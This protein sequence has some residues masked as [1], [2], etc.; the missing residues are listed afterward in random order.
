MSPIRPL[1]ENRGRDPRPVGTALE[2]L[3]RRLGAPAA[4][5][6]SA[7]F[8]QWDDIVGEV[9]AAHSRPLSLVDGVLTVAVDEPG[10]ATEFRFLTP[11]LLARINA[12]GGEGTAGRIEVR[13]RRF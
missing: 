3:A 8:T 9:V 5:S 7:V 11:T 12:L 13:V 1:P 6:L 2:A 10:W 4:S